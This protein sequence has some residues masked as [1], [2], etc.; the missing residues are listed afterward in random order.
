MSLNII[1]LSVI[2][3]GF[4]VEALNT[5]KREN[6]NISLMKVG[7]LTAYQETKKRQVDKNSAMKTRFCFKKTGPP[8][9]IMVLPM[10][11][12][13]TWLTFSF[14]LYF[15]LLVNASVFYR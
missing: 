5:G 8:G 14:D 7:K 13:L 10:P 1:S 4:N 15:Q 9:M 6:L 12:L 3:S 11:S 2:C